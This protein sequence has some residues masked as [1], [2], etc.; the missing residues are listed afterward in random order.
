MRDMILGLLAVSGVGAGVYYWPAG[1]ADVN[2]QS[3]SG[4][5]P[6]DVY[7]LSPA[8]A[9]S[10]L[11]QAQ[12][13]TGTAPFFNTEMRKEFAGTSRV[14]FKNAEGQTL[15]QAFILPS[16]GGVKVTPT[17]KSAA[18]SLGTSDVAGRTGTALM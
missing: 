6:S 16:D 9:V 14:D 4:N 13:R 10:R 2:P 7:P 5:A 12:T 8:E 17:C 3:P 15:C 11:S 1:G 18:R